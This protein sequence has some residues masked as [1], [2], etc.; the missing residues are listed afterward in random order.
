MCWSRNKSIKLLKLPWKELGSKFPC[1]PPDT[2]WGPVYRSLGS[3]WGHWC[4][5]HW[6]CQSSPVLQGSGQELSLHPKHPEKILLSVKV[7]VKI[8]LIFPSKLQFHFLKA[9]VSCYQVLKFLMLPFLCSFLEQCKLQSK[10]LTSLISVAEA[11]LALKLHST[12]KG[13]CLLSTLEHKNGWNFIFTRFE[14]SI[15]LKMVQNI[16]LK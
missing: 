14:A 12:L 5:P 6:S 3:K 8:E 9:Q 15:K 13:S 10:T 7:S 16:I 11:L 1:F 4:W 2:F